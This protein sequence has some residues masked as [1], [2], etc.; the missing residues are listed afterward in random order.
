MSSSDVRQGGRAW[1]QRTSGLLA[2]AAW[3]LLALPALAHDTAGDGTTAHLASDLL[4]AFGLPLAVLL[5]G[6]LGGVLLSTVLAHRGDAEKAGE[7]APT[8]ATDSPVARPTTAAPEQRPP[9][10]G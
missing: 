9:E 6:A 8:G 2:A 1:R 5:L 4:M 7:A 10:D 3:G